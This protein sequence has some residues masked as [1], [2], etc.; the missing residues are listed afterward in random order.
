MEFLEVASPALPAPVHYGLALLF[1][2]ILALVLLRAERGA[3]RFVIV[4]LWLRYM[5]AAFP[6]VTYKSVAAGLSLNALGSVVIIVAGIFFIDLRRLGW[7][8][9]LPIY[10]LLAIIGA[11]ALINGIPFAAVDPLLKW[12]YLLV[13]MLTFLRVMEG[14]APGRFLAL[15]ATTFIP[16]LG[17]QL[18]SLALGVAK[19]SESD[20]SASYIGGYNH[21]AAFSIILLTFVFVISITGAMKARTRTFATVLG[22]VGILM[23]N[24]RTTLLAVAPIAANYFVGRTSRGFVPRQRPLIVVIL[25]PLAMLAFLVFANALADRFADLPTVL[26]NGLDLVKS[27]TEF[28]AEEKEIFS[29]RMYIWSTYISAYMSGSQLQLLFGFGPDIWETQFARYAHNTVISYL[30]EFGLFGA[31]TVVAV[32]LAFLLRALAAEASVRG[33][34]LAA[35]G[36]FLILNMATMPHWLIEGDILYALICGYTL[37]T[38]RRNT[39]TA[40]PA[41]TILA[42]PNAI[43]SP[44]FK[45]RRLANGTGQTHSF[46]STSST[47]EGPS[48]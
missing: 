2:G 14:R 40:P 8:V 11:S 46:V 29:G 6:D 42:F 20:G 30:Y 19:A 24:Y 38:T 18:A 33:T 39:V 26:R 47:V 34:L 31:V 27:P 13:V 48:R 16:P 17:Y 41:R 5:M 9:F 4:A 3:E 22:V 32:W 10:M 37:F 35:H 43:G 1:T 25:L 45:R 28:T 7:A 12:L 21:E 44:A 36:S 23:A 15:L